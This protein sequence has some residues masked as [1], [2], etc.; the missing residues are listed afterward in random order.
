MALNLPPAIILEK[1]KLSSDSAWL[2]LLDIKLNDI[3]NTVLRF[4]NNN[5][6][7]VFQSQT[8]TA[9]PFELDA[10]DTNNTGEIPAITLRVSNITR[11]IQAYLEELNG[12]VGAEV[13]ITPIN[14]N[15]LGEDYSPMQ[16]KF[17]VIQTKTDPYWC[18]FTL[19]TPNPMNQRFPLYRY[20]A[21][22]CN[23]ASNYKGV[24]CKYSG[25]LPT[26]NGT[27]DDCR[28]HNNSKNFGGFKGLEDVGIR[29]V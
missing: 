6:D 9:F 16:L 24:E 8:Y 20:N 23:W 1:N 14:S 7:I 25:G 28:V 4:V 5:E 22:H 10:N 29:F 27:L 17:S 21:A 13:V 11:I 12:G 19:G 26:C 2:A 3:G 18:Y 15:H